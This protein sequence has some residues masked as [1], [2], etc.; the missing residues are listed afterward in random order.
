MMGLPFAILRPL[1]DF[2]SGV[3]GG[4][5]KNYIDREPPKDI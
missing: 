3:L 2:I 5:I 1:I 4:S